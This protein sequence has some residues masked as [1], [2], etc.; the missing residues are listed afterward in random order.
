MIPAMTWGLLA[1]A[2]LIAVVG[3]VLTALDRR[4]G[5]A[6]TALAALLEVGLLAQLVVGAVQLAG[7]DRS[8]DGLVF[9]GYLVGILLVLPTALTWS[10]SEPSRWGAGVLVVAG[11]VI[12]VLLARLQQIWAGPA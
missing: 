1:G 10:K 4:P 3:A 9:V 7:T 11:L 6:T 2:L 12:A 8:V 5:R